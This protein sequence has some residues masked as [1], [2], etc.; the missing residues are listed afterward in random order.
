MRAVLNSLENCAAGEPSGAEGVSMHG[1]TETSA[2]RKAIQTKLSLHAGCADGQGAYN[3][4][5]EIQRLALALAAKC[6]RPASRGAL[7]LVAWRAGCR[8]EAYKLRTTRPA[9]DGG[10][11]AGGDG[12]SAAARL[13]AVRALCSKGRSGYA[14]QTGVPFHPLEDP[15]EEKASAA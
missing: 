3:N 1:H 15:R 6:T 13:R 2:K 9:A 4:D 11:G 14:P 12:D 5:V 7:E 8:T 10:G